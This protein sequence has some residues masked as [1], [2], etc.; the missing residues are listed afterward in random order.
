MG[1]A[2]ATMKLAHA[3]LSALDRI[4]QS[5]SSDFI[6]SHCTPSI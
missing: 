3:L 2:I 6:P 1:K 4:L 5:P